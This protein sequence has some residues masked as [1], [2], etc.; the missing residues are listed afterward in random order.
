MVVLCAIAPLVTLF[1]YKLALSV[2][3]I[4]TSFIDNDALDSGV[5]AISGALDSLI[6]LYAVTVV[7]YSL[8]I[9]LFLRQGM[10]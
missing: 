7:I 9:M 5:K 3:M 2:V 4:F 1:M 6:A 10:N 8:E